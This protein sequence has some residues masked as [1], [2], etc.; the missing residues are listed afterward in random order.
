MMTRNTRPSNTVTR[1]SNTLQQTVQQS[2]Q[3]QW[4]QEP[5]IAQ[6]LIRGIFGQFQNPPE[7]RY[8]VPNVPIYRM[9]M[10]PSI[11]QGTMES[12]A[13][14]PDEVFIKRVYQGEH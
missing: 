11:Q 12:T 13:I 3:S 1:P 14:A 2:Q 10:L 6:R 7:T 8:G 9:P 5:T 4:R